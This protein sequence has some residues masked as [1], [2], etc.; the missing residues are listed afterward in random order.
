MIHS[1]SPIRTSINRVDDVPKFEDC[2]LMEV[3]LLSAMGRK[4]LHGWKRQ[5]G[6]TFLCKVGKSFPCLKSKDIIDD[7]CFRKIILAYKISQRRYCFQASLSP[8][9]FHA[10]GAVPLLAILTLVFAGN[11]RAMQR[12]SWPGY[13]VVRKCGKRCYK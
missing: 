8:F 13:G 3:T 9:S 11:A 4:V 2:V 12:A 10:F 7:R 6:S 5:N 1:F